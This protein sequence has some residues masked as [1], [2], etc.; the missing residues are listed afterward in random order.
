MCHILLQSPFRENLERYGNIILILSRFFNF[1]QEKGAYF[2]VKNF[3]GPILGEIN[4]TL[5]FLRRA[6]FPA[7]IDLFIQLFGRYFLHKRIAL[8]R[9]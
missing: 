2:M 4:S 1:I 8:G 7:K 5:L 9:D 6:E 3:F